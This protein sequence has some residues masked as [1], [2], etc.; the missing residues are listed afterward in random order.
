MKEKFK[1]NLLLFGKVILPQA[2]Y[3]DFADVHY[4]IQDVLVDSNI[5]HANIIVPRGIAKTTLASHIYPLFHCFVEE[6]YHNRPKVVVIISKTRDHSIFCLTAIKNILEYSTN[7]RSIFGYHGVNTAKTWREDIIVLDTGDVFIAKGMGQPIRGI[8][9]NSVR[10]SL[11]LCDDPEDENNTKTAESM[12][13]NVD[14]VIGGALRALDDDIGR[15]ILIGTPLHQS[16]LVETFSRAPNWHTIRR[17]YLNEDRNGELYSLWNDCVSVED[18]IKEKEDLEAIGKISKFYSERQCEI[19]GDEDQLFRP[20][21]IQEWDGEY[22]RIGDLSYLKLKNKENYV[23]VNVFM[24]VDPA[25]STKSTADFSVVFAIGIDADDRVFCIE[26]YRKR[27]RPMELADNIMEMYNRYRPEKVRIESIGY[28]EMLRDYLRVQAE[29]KKT[30]IPGLEI[31]EMPRNSKSARLE[32]LQPR[33]ANKKVFIRSNMEAFRD[34]LLSYPRGQND[35][36]LDAY[37]YAVKNIYKPYHS[38]LLQKPIVQSNFELDWK[39][40]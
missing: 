30:Y 21:Y 40:L 27:V 29:E 17:K 39:T 32:S 10:P 25:S 12:A 6:R 34:E 26:Y 19:V 5:K 9:Y 14:W 33:F 4:D 24:G 35:D 7:F 16:C 8:N 18:L 22:K 3:R 1:N 23:P 20:E 15:L 36:T 38:E 28:Q 2:F 13:A 37:F 11:I 31:K